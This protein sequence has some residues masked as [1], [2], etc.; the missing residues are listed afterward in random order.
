[1]LRF[2]SG[3]KRICTRKLEDSTHTV[4]YELFIPSQFAPRQL[5]FR[6]FQQEI[7]PRCPPELVGNKTF[8]VHQVERMLNSGRPCRAEQV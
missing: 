2:G 3:E 4:D 7:R 8:V 6:P 1:M 5:T